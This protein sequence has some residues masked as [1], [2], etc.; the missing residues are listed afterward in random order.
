MIEKGEKATNVSS[1]RAK[2]MLREKGVLV[3]RV[4]KWVISEEATKYLS[5]L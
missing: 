3:Y 5:M 4:R 2:K 1:L